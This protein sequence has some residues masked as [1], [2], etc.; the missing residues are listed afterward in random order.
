MFLYWP[1]VL[2]GNNLKMMTTRKPRISQGKL[3]LP[4][5]RHKKIKKLQ[6]SPWAKRAKLIQP[7]FSYLTIRHNLAAHA[8]LAFELV[9]G[10]SWAAFHVGLTMTLPW[11]NNLLLLRKLVY[12][13]Y[14]RV[15]CHWIKSILKMNLFSF[16][17]LFLVVQL[18]TIVHI[19]PKH[20]IFLFFPSS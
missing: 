10:L 14:I 12:S 4:Q 17:F 7:F 1:M 11:K 9:I 15:E 18:M 16:V 3:A 5:L 6:N 20:Y 8:W 13:R 2:F 19:A